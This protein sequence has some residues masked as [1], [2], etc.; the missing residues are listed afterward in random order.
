MKVLYT[1][2]F[3]LLLGLLIA[4]VLFCRNKVVPRC[5]SPIQKLVAL[6]EAKIMFN[7]VIRACLQTF[8]ATSIVLFYTVRQLNFS[9]PEGISD[10][11]LVVLVTVYIFGFT[12]GSLKFIRKHSDD[13]R[14]LVQ[15]EVRLLLLKCQLLQKRSPIERLLVPCEKDCRRS[16]DLLASILTCRPSLGHR[17]HMHPDARQLHHSVANEHQPYQRGLSDE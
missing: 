2:C 10:I 1:L 4:L 14:T 9:S 13:L 16:R 3:L 7:S 12:F 5:W 17:H 6:L 15:A 11:F 8:F